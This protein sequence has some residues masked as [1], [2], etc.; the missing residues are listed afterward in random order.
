MV[1]SASK[2]RDRLLIAGERLIAE[3]GPAVSL[4]EIVAVA[5]QRNTAAVHY[6]FGSRD[7]LIEA[8]VTCRQ[9]SLERERLRLLATMESA[10]AGDLRGL[11]GLLISPLLSVPY[12]EGSTHYARFLEKVRDHPSIVDWE[13]DDWPATTMVAAQLGR[14]LVELPEQTRKLRLRALMTTAFALLA[15]LERHPPRAR[16]GRQVETELV[17]MLLGLLTAES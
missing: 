6:H 3:Q 8:I 5:G 10:G 2:A 12:S 14:H 11:I 4:R 17:D 16:L 13:R 7:G 9:A 1:G 15:D